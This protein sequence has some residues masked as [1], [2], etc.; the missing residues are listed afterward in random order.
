MS[1]LRRALA[2][3]LV[4]ALLAGPASAYHLPDSPLVDDTA[5]T[6]RQAEFRAGVLSLEGGVTDFL[7][8][9]TMPLLWLFKVPNVK[10]KARLAKVGDLA[11]S[12]EAGYATFS[13]KP[14]EAT[15]SE[16]GIQ[17]IPLKAAIS[18]RFT[19]S[20]VSAELVYNK[21]GGSVAA[22]GEADGAGAVGGAAVAVTSLQSTG[23]MEYRLGERAAIMIHGRYVMWQDLTAST[24]VVVEPDAFTSI[25]MHGAIK[26]DN[27]DIDVR[28]AYSVSGFFHWS[29]RT[30][31]LRL[32][33]GYG[34]ATI[35]VLNLISPVAAP[36]PVGDAYFKWHW[37][38]DDEESSEG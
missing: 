8:A 16:I 33:L 21:I 7:S 9:G 18:Y 32:G 3:A 20:T 19:D 30:F 36:Y 4:V 2:A 24:D 28:G 10:L 12:A 35:P 6:L 5:F 15:N 11:V 26:A 1:A 17:V 38:G 27:E 31:N 37:G 34:H 13:M 23:T 14:D 22:N 25:E 29:W